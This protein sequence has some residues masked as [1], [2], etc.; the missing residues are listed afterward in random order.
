MAGMGLPS[1]YDKDNEEWGFFLG[2][3]GQPSY[4]ADQIC[5]WLWKKRVFDPSEMTDFPKQTREELAGKVDFFPPEIESEKSSGDGSR[6]FLIRMRDGV[7]IETVL[8]KQGDR[9]T[10]CLSTQAGCPIGCP[11]CATGGSGFERNLTPG[12]IASQLAVMEKAAG[13]EINNVVLMGMGEP[14]LNTEAVLHAVRILNNPKMR[15]LGIRHIT[16]ST[17]GIIPG[18]VALAESGLGVRLAVSL[19]ASD[20]ELRDELV[21]C[22]TTYPVKELVSALH[23]YQ[24]VTGD[25]V[26]IEYALF[27]GKNDSIGHARTLVRLLHGLHSFVNLIPA[28]A[29]R[30]GYERSHAED[31]LKFQSVLKSAGFES[32]IR[33]ARGGEINAAC[34]Q[35]RRTAEP[36]DA[37]TERRTRTTTTR[38][39]HTD[40]PERSPSSKSLH[41]G[42]KE[43]GKEARVRS[44]GK[45]GE[46]EGPKNEGPKRNDDRRERPQRDRG[47]HAGW[48]GGDTGRGSGA[49]GRGAARPGGSRRRKFPSGSNASNGRKDAGRAKKK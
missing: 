41:A 11:F 32:E 48:S 31:V 10:A 5:G 1:A 20:D 33:A 7:R 40:R 47:A 49:G 18:I 13:R 15:G 45:A 44:S 17:A 28:N 6:K 12:E 39:R 26:T 29:V 24:R 34:G 21:P 14:F 35:L 22:N 4:R 25:R 8:L 3:L 42:R 30:P 16:I 23:E 2:K 46:N 27:N 37:P 9:L 36:A 43:Q 38:E 19:H